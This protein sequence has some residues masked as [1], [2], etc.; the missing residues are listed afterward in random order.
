MNSTTLIATVR[1]LCSC[2]VI[3][4]TTKLHDYKPHYCIPN[5]S[6]PNISNSGF[7]TMSMDFWS[8]FG[9]VANIPEALQNTLGYLANS[10]KPRESSKQQLYNLC[11]GW[12]LVSPEFQTP[13]HTGGW[14]SRRVLGY[15]HVR[16]RCSYMWC[17][18][19]HAQPLCLESSWNPRLL[20]ILP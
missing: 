13:L 18:H 19:Y 6:I 17:E 5:L 10:S 2:L 8:H 7:T 20:S 4:Y 14:F 15:V 1:W 11:P 12:A 16:S 9:S 3:G